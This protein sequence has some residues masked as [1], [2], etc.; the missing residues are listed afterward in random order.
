MEIAVAVCCRRSSRPLE[1]LQDSPWPT[2]GDTSARRCRCHQ[3]LE[4]EMSKPILQLQRLS[5][6]FG[7]LMVNDCIDLEILA[8]ETHAVI[9]P[10]GPGKSPLISQISGGVAPDI[11]RIAFDGLDVTELPM[12]AR[13]HR[14]V[15]RSFQ[16]THVLAKFTALENAALAVQAR[17]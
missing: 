6:S 7:A 15:A 13:A 8:G 9:G 2:A 1:V 5:K 17:S 12:P 4:A 3:S 11:G 16:I 14:G 10:N